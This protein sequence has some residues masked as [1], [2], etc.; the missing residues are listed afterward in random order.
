MTSNQHG[1][2]DL[3]SAPPPETGETVAQR[4]ISRLERQARVGILRNLNPVPRPPARRPALT[5]RWPCLRSTRRPPDARVEQ[6]AQQ[7]LAD[8]SDG[9]AQPLAGAAVRRGADGQ[10]QRIDI[11][12]LMASVEGLGVATGG[13]LRFAATMR[14]D[15]ESPADPPPR[16]P[17]PPSILSPEAWI[18]PEDEDDDAL[19]E[20]FEDARQHAPPPAPPPVRRGRLWGVLIG[21]LVAL[22]IALLAPGWTPR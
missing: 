20:A 19:A 22:V 9:D 2:S 11:A 15:G 8:N 5:G 7:Y 6:A 12:G 18:E 10:L 3:G 21:L 4:R 13:R 16:S 1:T 14:A 17:R